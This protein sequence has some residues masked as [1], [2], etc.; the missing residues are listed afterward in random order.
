[1]LPRSIIDDLIARCDIETLISSYVTLKRTG[2]NQKGLCPFHSER[3]PSFTVYPQTQSFYCFGC[4]AGGNAI[5]FIMR[6]E[7]LDFRAAVEQLA[8]RSGVTLPSWD[9]RNGERQDTGV[10]RKR[11][12]AM[13]L[14][15]AKFYRAMLFDEQTGSAGRAYFQERGLTGSTVKHFGLG[16][17]PPTGS[18]TLRHLKS[19]GFGE[20]EIRQAYF[21]GKSERGYYDYFRG[22]VMF[23]IID[24]SGNV[25]AFGGRVLDDTKPKYLNTSDTPAFKKS[26]NLFALNYAKNHCEDGFILCEGY[27]DVIALH[28]AGFE[29]AVAT[30]GTAITSE[31]ARLLKKY[32]D[33]VMIS[34]DSDEA[35][36]KA[37]NRAISL[38]EEAGMEA[39]VIRIPDAKDPDEYIKK[40]G[41]EKFRQVLSGSQSKFDYML[42]N[43]RGKYNLE[44][45]EEKIKA[46]KEVCRYIAGVYSRVEREIYIT[47]TAEAFAVGRDS[48]THDVEAAIRQNKREAE[49]KRK[50]ELFRVTSGIGDRVNPDY[51]KRPKAA[52]LEE[53]VLGMIFFKPEYAEAAVREGLLA[54]E[55]FFTDLGKRLYACVEN[56]V[57]NDGFSMPM[58][59]E[60]FTQ[61]EVS[62]A[63]RMQ[64]QR[65]ELPDSPEI[66]RTYAAELR[67][68]VKTAASSLS[69]E[70]LVAQKRN[71][72]KG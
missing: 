40:F 28:A 52:R 46:V 9:D 36:Q 13:N 35:G 70:E 11:V 67:S 72:N 55:D 68:E 22:R 61:D 4:G 1:M 62:R 51:A 60:N 69:L 15:A 66:F 42:H 54:P 57:K 24:V 71:Q 32:A 6:I 41:A 39:R 45:P 12:L 53:D 64:N 48:I 5:D 31:Q 63:Y 23:P 29:N 49:K 50:G 18:Q 10:S 59:S 17:A 14:E 7:N 43:T 26:R 2:T 20:E 27:M 38:L 58:L 34:Y 21:C 37:A 44:I 19:L 47:K 25:I 8:D 56:G 30:L 33:R 3:T 16:Y 65:T